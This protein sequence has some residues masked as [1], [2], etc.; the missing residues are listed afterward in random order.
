MTISVIIPVYDAEQYIERC[1]DSVI[2][3]NCDGF[4]IE[5]ILVDDCSPDHSMDI[6][7]EKIDL[8]NGNDISFHMI[9]HEVNKGLSAARNTGIYTAKGD[10]LFFLDADDIILENAFKSLLFYY[11]NYSAVDVVMGNTLYEEKSMLQNETATDNYTAPVV[12]DDRTVFIKMLLRRKINRFAWNKLVRRSFVMENELFFDDGI[13]Y[14]DVI[15]TYRLFCSISSFI[16]VPCVTYVYKYNPSSIVHTREKRAIHV[17][18]SFSFICNWIFNNPP[19]QAGKDLF[20]VE[21]R[22]FIFYSFIEA[23]DCKDR[24]GVELVCNHL[25]YKLKRYLLFDSLKH[26]HLLMGMFFLLMFAPF[27]SF[28]KFH[29]FRANFDRI[30]KVVYYLSR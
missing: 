25:F 9:S 22:L 23:I 7:R 13:I 8:Y 27:K 11:C 14:E 20:Y 2:A 18:N 28:L 21:H 5:C 17:V 10:F 1:L 19:R 26:S 12:F 16:Q 29:W 6:V 24:F 4:D 30:E 3:Q 15:W